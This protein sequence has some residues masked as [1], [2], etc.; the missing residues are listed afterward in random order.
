[1]TRE[2]EVGPQRFASRSRLSVCRPTARWRADSGVGSAIDISA[3]VIKEAL[4]CWAGWAK[5]MFSCEAAK[6]ACEPRLPYYGSDREGGDLLEQPTASEYANLSLQ[7]PTPKSAILPAFVLF[8]MSP[9][10]AEVLLGATRLTKIGGLFLVA[11]FYGCGVLLIRELVRRRT[12]SWWPVVLFGAAYMLV[13]EGLRFR[14]SSTRISSTLPSS[15]DDG[16]A[17]ISS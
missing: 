7:E 1:M 17:S 13:E 14:R 12:T 6:I 3:P 4:D 5:S 15:G 16:T 9:L 10:I 11:P 8:L 2:R